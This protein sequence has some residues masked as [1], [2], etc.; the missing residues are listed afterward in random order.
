VLRDGKAVAERG[1]LLWIFRVFAMD[2]GVREGKAPAEPT[3]QPWPFCSSRFKQ[4][5]FIVIVVTEH[6]EESVK[7]QLAK[8]NAQQFSRRLTPVYHS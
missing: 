2:H 6:M 5:S 3:T 1:C 8:S 7:P 4:R